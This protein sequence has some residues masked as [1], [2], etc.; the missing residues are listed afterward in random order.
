MAQTKDFYELLGV[1]KSATADEIKKAYR[2]LA[3]QYHPDKNPDNK[4]AEEKFK[5]INN[6]Y[7][8]IGDA[9]KRANYDRFGSERYTQAGGPSQAGG[10]GRDDFGF[11]FDFNFNEGSPF[12]DLNDVFEQMFGFGNKR[13]GTESRRS[14]V[15]IEREIELTLEEIANGVTKTFSYTHNAVCDKC[16]GKGNEPGTDFKTCHTCKGAGRVFTRQS[17]I[18]GIVQQES[19]CPTCAGAGKEFM[20]A[21]TKCT[22]RGFTQVSEEI[23]IPIPA[24]I[25]DSQKI[26]VTGKGEAGYRGS[27]AGDLLLNVRIRKHPSLVRVEDNIESDLE[28]TVFDLLLGCKRDVYTVWGDVEVEIPPLTAPDGKLRL[29]SQGIPKISNPSVRG[30]HYIN[31]RPKMPK[32]LS[33]E[34]IQMLEQVRNKWTK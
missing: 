23:Q 31:I 19:V 14:G 33:S 15:N 3:H 29:K 11:G 10:F 16:S 13:G 17:T 9:K 6:A 34:Q 26:K 8:V 30:D 4:E 27:T 21:C 7:E 32:S 12:G 5:E 28:I 2:K 18:F 20:K 1:S 24:G 22:G 25:N